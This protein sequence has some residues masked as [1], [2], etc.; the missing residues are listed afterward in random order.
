MAEHHR[1]LSAVVVVLSMLATA[2]GGGGGDPVSTEAA[3]SVD[4]AQPAVTPPVSP[5]SEPEP[6]EIATPDPVDRPGD[7]VIAEC[8]DVPVIRATMRGNLA[9]RLGW[10]G[11]DKVALGTYMDGHAEQSASS[12]VDP[13]RGTVVAAFTADA[14]AHQ[15]AIDRLDLDTTVEAV[16]VAFSARELSDAMDAFIDIP[17]VDLGDAIRLRSVGVD[18]RR[19][20][21][22]IG[23][24]DPTPE[25]FAALA[26][27]GGLVP[28][29]AVCVRVE[30]TPTAPDGPLEVIPTPGIDDATL[31][32][33][34]GLLPPA[35]YGAVRE[36]T[37]LAEVNHPS[38]DLFGLA[39]ETPDNGVV[40]GDWRLWHISDDEA[41]YRS[42][43][44]PR[45]GHVWFER[46]GDDW[47]FAGARHG[48]RPCEIRVALPHGL[49]DVKVSL[50]P[51]A[52]PDPASTSVGLLVREADC[53]SG[54][55][56]GDALLAPQV[57]ETPDAVLVA[58]A[59]VRS[60]HDDCEGNP[61][62]R[63]TIELDAPL[64]D[65]VLLDGLAITPTPLQDALEDG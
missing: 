24:L 10:D 63:V 33:C 48:G 27:L 39:V 64:G 59:V 38:A 7:D 5:T 37:P 30:L 18:V 55:E 56:M 4:A 11:P 58:F 2:C 3:P 8:A 1:R 32:V 29:A 13:A 41:H 44:R 61:T 57:V 51:D 31:V 16:E 50:D 22:Q 21:L 15:D 46:D 52:P 65:R 42:I 53:A 20:R 17:Q 35:P 62:S 54:R 34:Q 49:G 43:E 60:V 19:N 28:A 36:A 47:F 40:D 14:A 45:N 25:T 9:P 6:A 26:G 12:W 23:V